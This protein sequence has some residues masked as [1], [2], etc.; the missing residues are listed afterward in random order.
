VEIIGVI[1]NLGNLIVNILI[2]VFQPILNPE[3]VEFKVSTY[4]GTVGF[5]E[6]PKAVS[7]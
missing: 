3:V 4:V 2:G 1:P 5:G 6:I 7:V